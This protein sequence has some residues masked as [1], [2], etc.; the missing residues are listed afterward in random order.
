MPIPTGGTRTLVGS[1]TFSIT[2]P[3]ILFNYPQMLGN[4]FALGESFCET[5]IGALGSFSVSVDLAYFP[6][7]PPPY[8]TTQFIVGNTGVHI[9]CCGISAGAAPAN[10]IVT[11]PTGTYSWSMDTEFISTYSFSTNT[12]LGIWEIQE[13]P[14]VGGTASVSIKFNGVTYS[15]SGTI[16][17][18]YA[19]PLLA[20][21][22]GHQNDFNAQ[23]YQMGLA[24][25][26]SANI[27]LT[28]TWM[29]QAFSN[30]FNQ[31]YGGADYFKVDLTSGVSVTSHASYAGGGLFGSALIV[32]QPTKQ[33]VINGQINAFQEAY[34]ASLVTE[35]IGLYP[36][37][38]TT[39]Y[40]PFNFGDTVALDNI[41]VNIYGL[42][43]IFVPQNPVYANTQ[44]DGLT[45]RINPA[46]LTAA[47]EAGTV[48]T[49]TY[50][51]ARLK[52]FNMLSLA[53]SSSIVVDPCTES[54]QKA[55]TLQWT[56]H[57]GTFTTG[58]TVT[59][60][61]SGATGTV[62]GADYVH[63]LL[64]IQI[65]S[66]SFDLTHTITGGTSGATA[67]G[68]FSY[69]SGPNN[70]NWTSNC[71]LTGG[72]ITVDS[73][74]AGYFNAL[75][76][77]ALG[78][79]SRTNLNA[80]GT[81]FTAPIAITEGYRYLQMEVQPNT[82]FVELTYSSESGSFTLG[83]T[84]NQ[85]TSGAVGA[86]VS[87]NN[88][89]A[90]VVTVTSGTF[91][92]GDVITGAISGHT[93]T[94]TVVTLIYQP[95]SIQLSD[96]SPQGWGETVFWCYQGV[97]GAAGSVT[98]LTFDLMAPTQVIGLASQIIVT[99][100]SETGS[101]TIGEVVIQDTTFASGTVVS[102]NHITNT[103]TLQG[104]G[105]TFLVGDAVRGQTS[106][107]Y[108]V[109]T[110]VSGGNNIYI[111]Q[112][113]RVLD[114]KITANA[115]SEGPGW[116]VDQLWQMN[117]VFP[118]RTGTY[119]LKG[120][121]MIAN[122]APRVSFLQSLTGSPTEWSSATSPTQYYKFALADTDG[123]RS[124]C[125]G[126]IP[127]QNGY[128]DTAVGGGSTPPNSPFTLQAN[129]ITGWAAN[130]IAS[131]ADINAWYFDFNLSNLA[132]A[133]AIYTGTLPATYWID[134]AI[135]NDPGS[136]TTIP[137]QAMAYQVLFPPQ[138]GDLSNGAAPGDPFQWY[139]LQFLRQ[140]TTGVA[141]DK[142]SFLP[143]SGATVTESQ[144][145]SGV[146]QGSGTTDSQ[147]IFITGDDY[148]QTL[149]SQQDVLSGSTSGTDH[150]SFPANPRDILRV[151][152]DA[153]PSTSE[154]RPWQ[155]QDNLG[156]IHLATVLSGDVF[157]R[158]ANQ[159]TPVTGWATAKKV[160]SWGDCQ[161][162]RMAID[163]ELKRIHMLVTRYTGGT[164]NVWWVYSDDD[165][166][167]F[168]SGTQVAT[169][170]FGIAVCEL[171]ISAMLMTWFV[172]N[173]GTSGPGTQKG[174]YSPGS[175]Q[176]FGAVFTFKNS[177]SSD[178][179]VAD[180]GWSNVEE[181]KDNA[182]A[183]VWSPILNGDISPTV[184]RSYDDGQTWS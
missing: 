52:P 170:G 9:S 184:L 168:T 151:V 103:L 34:P 150:V 112:P 107:H 113:T 40:A 115:P 154:T 49:P 55:V 111:T 87:D 172:Y 41:I 61:T 64:Q 28:P 138:C 90:L 134:K 160:T 46:S 57:T 81:T 5:A 124:F 45:C 21:G 2:F 141:I 38:G 3:V 76:P 122:N 183:L 159:T 15:S 176:A 140:R 23:I 73:G 114:S 84:V 157:Y 12:R 20:I 163:P 92:V 8:L 7:G 78:I 82:Q 69:Y 100:A 155:Y 125:I 142:G 128:S 109:P 6:F 74:T 29:G 104:I 67:I 180:G 116:G 16:T 33:A 177:S 106:A 153:I 89:N 53:Q 132:G 139:A 144:L 174:Q 148:A 175:G 121:S 77:Y 96:I 54:I 88:T 86:V 137:H 68:P 35:Y 47:G 93:T 44:G 24:A 119:T 17:A 70:E 166:S 59:Q 39:L 94:P 105:G 146:A 179:Q 58:E 91:A 182:N 32:W 178:I 161:Y 65:A 102:D 95:I 10:T 181:S 72:F 66:G 158:R 173:A 133:G 108:C 164:Y 63:S 162:A 80:N 18:A 50:L 27:T 101:F 22:M 4:A 30:S 123:K 48:N 37:N 60:A 83:E 98:T 79:A 13:R 127:L 110:S 71:S 165:G 130:V 97:L 152:F 1:G 75:F 36:T 85:A 120:I 31:T 43:T 19:T 129:A 126:D 11:D 169:N 145:I 99:Y 171:N 42:S 131:T 56:S 118:A 51:P 25:S 143:I 149:Y 136:P 135:S 167:T 156:N 26:S 117:F 14:K 62:I 147:G